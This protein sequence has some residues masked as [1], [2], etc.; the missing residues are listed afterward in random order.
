[1]KTLNFFLYLNFGLVL[2]GG[3]QNLK[4]IIVLIDVG[5]IGR[6]SLANQIALINSHHPKLIAIDLQFS[7]DTDFAVDTK[8]I[9]K[10]DKCK[11]LIMAS[12]IENYTGDKESYARFTYG[13]L[14]DYKTNAKT[15]F[16]NMPYNDDLKNKPT[17]FSTMERVNGDIEYHFAVRIAMGIDSVSTMNFVQNNR[18]IVEIDYLAKTKPFLT[19]VLG[20]T[21][22]S[23]ELIEDKVI[24]LGCVNNRN[25]VSTKRSRQYVCDPGGLQYL[26][27]VIYQI[28][29]K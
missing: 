11:N 27:Q 4:P 29:K 21:K 1:M 7:E 6:D 16:V 3:A 20:G 5:G 9:Q 12:M 8:L 14:P 2:I 25:K 19:T 23:A 26:G 18:R 10:L 28:L 24:V 13:S 15:G 22:I 17:H